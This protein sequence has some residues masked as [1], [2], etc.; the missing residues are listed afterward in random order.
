M[1]GSTLTVRVPASYS[2]TLARVHERLTFEG[3]RVVSELDLTRSLRDDLGVDVPDQTILGVCRSQLAHE[4]LSVSPTVA[5]L[6]PCSVVVRAVGE[7]GT[8]V[9]TIDPEALMALIGDHPTLREL[10]RDVRERLVATLSSAV[11]GWS[12]DKVRP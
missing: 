3:L 12:A 11:T 6:F 10:A 5:M 1:P 7:S 4:A 2:D 8:L 9:Q